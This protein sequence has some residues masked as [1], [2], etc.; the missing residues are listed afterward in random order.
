MKLKGWLGFL[1]ICLIFGAPMLRAADTESDH[2]DKKLEEDLKALHDEVKQTTNTSTSIQSSTLPTAPKETPKPSTPAEPQASAPAES[3]PQRPSFITEIEVRGNNIVGTNTVLGKIKSQ[4]GT[5]LMQETV[6]EDIKRLYATGFFEDIKIEVKENPQGYALVVVVLE[7]PIIRKIVL[8]GFKSFKEDKLRKELKVSEGQVLDRKAVKQ[9][10]EAIRKL[11]ANKGFRFVDVNSDVNIDR[12]TNETTIIVRVNEGEK[13]KIRSIK[14]M[15]NKAFKAKQLNKLMKTKSKLRMFF[16]SGVFKSDDFDEDLERLQLFYQKEGYLDVK[17]APDFKYDEKAQRIDI[18]IQIEEGP[19]YLCG[20]IK[21]KGNRLFPESEIWQELEMLPGQTYS[22]YYLSQDLEKIRQYYYTRGYMDARIIPDTQ[23]NKATQKV[24]V[25]YTIEEGDLYFVEK[26]VVRG[27]TKTRDIVIRRELRIRPGE[28][29]DGGKIDKSKQRLENLG[30]FEEV[31][32]DT[33]PSPSATNRKDLIFRVKE[34]RTGEL[35]FGGGVSSVDNLVGFAE[36]S[37]KNFDWLNW[38]RFTGGGQSLSIRGRIGTINQSYNVSF[39]NPYIFNKPLAYGLDLFNFRENSKSVD[40]DENRLG[41]TN[42]ISKLFKDVFRLGTGYTLE[43]VKLDHLSD[44]APQAVRD[45]EGKN[46]LSR[47]KMFTNYDTRDNVFNPT[48]GFLGTFSGEMI[49]GFLGGDQD[50]YILDLSATKYWS[51]FKKQLL[52]TK[53]RVATSSDFGDS[54]TVPV[55]DRFYAGG[56]GTVRGVNYRR[57]G[58]KENGNPVGGQTL[59]VIN[60]DYNF[61]IP[62]LDA[63]RGVIFTDVGNVNS[64][65][66]KIFTFTGTVISVGPGIKVKT[67][68]GPVAL[69][70]GFP[71]TN[72]DDKNRNGR[73]EFSLSRGF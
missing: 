64:D 66:Y 12:A 13:Y 48:K 29:F 38:P 57:V 3:V 20:D 23:L 37:Q 7:K 16:R 73:F 58:P 30:F 53:L 54:D 2:L 71:L 26:V 27:N 51:L 15:G 11:Y 5:H 49:G 35:S 31:T 46:W 9:G 42:T 33:E 68:F 32:Y 56:L 14:F 61:P 52:E 19:K 24:D 39:Y 55:F 45:F 36:I 34:K 69:Y 28:K 41:V 70:Y 4:K 8:E 40:F 72:R 44:D 1:V 47:W 10:V 50:Y 59:K 67:P 63:F 18:T 62:R 65:S 22:Q 43:R 6:N 17:V 60:L 21:I 25:T